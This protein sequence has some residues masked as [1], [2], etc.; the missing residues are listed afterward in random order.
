MQSID[1]TQPGSPGWWFQ[2]LLIEL[3]DR[4]PRYDK[5]ER[6]ADGEPDLPAGPDGSR[7]VFRRFQSKARANWADLI[8]EATKERMQVAGFRTGAV[9]DQLGDDEAWK[10]WQANSLDADSS[11]LHRSML[12]MSDAYMIVGSVD[13]ETGQP[14]ITPED[15]REVIT[16]HAPTNRRRSI[17]ALKC[18]ADDVTGDEVAYVYLPGRVYTARKSGGDGA[19]SS[20]YGFKWTN[21]QALPSQASGLVPV[22]RFAN[23]A[24]LRGVSKGEFEDV[25]DDIDRINIM[26]LQRLVVAVMQAFRQR[27]VKGLPLTDRKNQPIDWSAVLTADPGSLWALPDGADLWESSGVDLTPI[28]ESVKAD[29]RDLAATTRT[30]MFYLFPD[31]ANGS[32]EGAS[33]QREG[34]IFKCRDRIRQ[35][36]ESYEQ[37]MSA[38]FL[39]KND[40]ARAAR[41]DMEVLWHPPEHFS[42]AER[43]DAASK[44]TAGGVPWRTVMSDIWQFTPQ[45]IA[46]MEQER[47]NDAFLTASLAVPANGA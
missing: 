25:I 45:Q 35:T 31:A 38:A 1:T 30:P 11:I 14:L 17:A 15:P 12:A 21:E 24:N 6:Y 18:F 39:M 8:V 36:T 22:F 42:L 37:V 46:R 9:P 41:S 4:R 7:E 32:A 2:K 33:L 29:A 10:I 20:T 43:A 16:A 23:R 40:L 27:A 47:S 5:L 28:L 13:P 26:L 44:A 19:P 3:T 34:L